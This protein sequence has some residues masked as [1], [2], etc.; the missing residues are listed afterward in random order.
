MCINYTKIFQ[1][2]IFHFQIVF[3]PSHGDP[4][5][6]KN[7]C[8]QTFLNLEQIVYIILLIGKRNIVSFNIFCLAF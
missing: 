3:P 5:T 2:N 6:F 8:F 7:K 4:L 1:L